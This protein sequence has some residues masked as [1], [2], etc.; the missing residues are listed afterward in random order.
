MSLRSDFVAVGSRLTLHHTFGGR[1]TPVLFI[2]GLGS[3]G[4]IEWRFNLAHF[5]TNHRVYAPDLPGY[6]RSDKP[7]AAR[8]GIPYFARVIDRYMEAQG[9]RRAA[10]VGTSMGGR[11]ALELA[12]KYPA[13]V[14]RL[15]LVNSLGLGRPKIQPYY[16]VMLMPRVGETLLHGMK[17][18]L[19]LAPAPVIRRIAARYMGAAEGLEKT[20]SDEYLSHMREMYA[21]EGYSAAYLATVRAIASPRSFFGDLDVS[22][23][24]AQVQVPLLLVWGAR[25][26]LF[27]LEHATRAHRAVPGSRLVVIQGAGHT[28]Q[29]ERPEEFNQQLESFLRP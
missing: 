13:R 17:H 26:P 27:P 23:R 12:L 4:Y 2:H 7:S 5:V 25:D 10:V 20:M 6:G 29:A 14:T 9:L 16:P 24:L 3:S 19:R 8:Y 28:P 15:A 22:R 18:A 11:I 1:G 21:A